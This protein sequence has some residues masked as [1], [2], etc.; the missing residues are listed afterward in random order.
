MDC[1]RAVRTVAVVSARED[2]LLGQLLA[3][4]PCSRSIGGLIMG[5]MFHTGASWFGLSIGV[6][7]LLESAVFIVLRRRRDS[8][9]NR[10]G[11]QQ[12]PMLL[13]MGVMFTSGSAARLRGWTGTGMTAVFLVGMVAAGATIMLAIRSLAAR[14]SALRQGAP[15]P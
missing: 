1:I 8:A 9:K 6:V 5:T 7:L 15:R 10:Q 4:G 11:Y 2:G 14:G 12:V 3:A 13:C